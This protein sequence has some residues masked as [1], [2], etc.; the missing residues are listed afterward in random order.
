[1]KL[2]QFWTK[3][4]QLAMSLNKEDTAIRFLISELLSLSTTDFYLKQDQDL[5]SEDQELLEQ[6]ISRYLYQHEP[7]QYIVGYTYFCDL[8]LEVSP[9]VLIPRF[10]TE[11]LVDLVINENHLKRPTILDIGTG[12]GAIALALKK[13]IPDST[14]YATDISEA[15]LKVAALNANRLQLDVH[16]IQSDLFANISSK[17][18]I[19]VSN[20]PYI[21]AEE[22]L[23]AIVKNYEPH[24]ALFAPQKGLFYYETILKQ[25]RNYVNETFLMAMEI[26]I[27]H[28]EEIREMANRYYSDA[29]ITILK[30]LSHRSRMLLIKSK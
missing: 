30:D 29:K 13:N 15:A 14:I 21:D 28:D 10:E 11:E 25:A 6:A 20:P 17:V 4:K 2:Q 18:D 24:L 19:I 8:K 23:E 27:N 3:Y 1:M 9:F 12:S 5:T 16:F 7:V 26:P 22:E